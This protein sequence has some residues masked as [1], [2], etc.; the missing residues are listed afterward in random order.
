MAI[1]ATLGKEISMV[2]DTSTTTVNNFSSLERKT[3]SETDVV[4]DVLTKHW[5]VSMGYYVRAMPNKK[6][7][8]RWKVQFVSYTKKDCESLKSTKKEW[9]IHKDRWRPLGFLVT[10]SLEEARSRAKQLNALDKIKKQERRVQKIREEEIRLHISNKAFLPEEFVAEF[11]KRFIRYRDS[12]TENGKRQLSRAHVIWRAG[13]RMIMHLKIDPME[14]FERRYEVYDYFYQQSFSISYAKKILSIANLWGYFICKKLGKPYL[15]IDNPR[16]HERQRIV[17]NYFDQNKSKKSKPL[18]PEKLNSVRGEFSNENFNWL[19]LSVW[20][21]L[22]PKEID[23]TKND[24]LWRVETLQTG[25]KVLWLYQTK[26]VA[27]PKEERWKG[28]PIIHDEQKFALKIL[29]SKNFKRPHHQKM[30]EVLGHSFQL[31]GGRKGFVDLMLQKGHQLEAISQWMGHSTLGRTW[32]DYKDRRD[33][34]FSL[35]A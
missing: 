3:S 9:D 8:P 33:I 29:E 6:K 20:F 35:P 31:Y 14:W 17:D 24:D 4:D 15:P 5:R 7:E 34:L 30:K 23:N 28:I 22:R 10:M 16:G 26:L 19:Y 25:L 11:E 32:R 18:K 2:L 13:Q 12:E 1:L 27:I 21:G